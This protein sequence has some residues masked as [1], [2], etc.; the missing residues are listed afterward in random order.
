[1]PRSAARLANQAELFP[2]R[3]RFGKAAL[4]QPPAG[5]KIGVAL[6]QRPDRMQM[7]R[8]DDECVDGEGMTLPRR[9]DRLAQGSNLVHQQGLP[10]L[11]QVDREEKAAARDDS[12]TWET[13]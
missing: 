3:Q 6:W 11:Q 2:F 9:G 4:D 7:V 1:M 12:S 8:Q 13:G 10:P 5:R